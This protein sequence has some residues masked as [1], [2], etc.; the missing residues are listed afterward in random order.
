[1]SFSVTLAGKEHLAA[2]GPIETAA[3]TLFSEADLPTD[4]RYRVTATDILRE[5]Q[6]DARIWVA[7][8]DGD[9]PVGFAMAT[10]VDNEAHLDELNVMPNYGRRGIGTE[11]VKA[12]TRWARD[13]GFSVLTLITFKHLPWN[14][15][16]YEKQGFVRLT[17]AELDGELAGLIAEEGKAGIDVNKRL[18]MQLVL[19]NTVTAS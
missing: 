19:D 10:L 18:A 4:I 9:L 16:F 13:E 14:A 6:D 15:A 17:A 8:A 3:A 7:L 5:A 11:L 1:V 12:V 2:I